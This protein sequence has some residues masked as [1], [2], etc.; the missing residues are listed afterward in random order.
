MN[1]EL[2]TVGSGSYA[3]MT[4][5]AGPDRDQLEITIAGGQ[6]VLWGER[7]R[8]RLWLWTASGRQVTT[9]AVGRPL[10]LPPRL[11]PVVTGA[12][13]AAVLLVEASHRSHEA[14]AA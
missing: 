4:Q 13:Q 9:H 6:T 5:P 3:V 8:D 10:T 12:A 7:Y 2:I 14:K 11:N 1:Y